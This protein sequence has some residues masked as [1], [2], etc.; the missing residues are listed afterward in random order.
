M[1][2]SSQSSSHRQNS[3]SES[4]Q[5]LQPAQITI[6]DRALEQVGDFGEVRL[7]VEKGKLRY[8][9]VTHSLDVLKIQSSL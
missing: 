9:E 6:I 5:F 2:N 1:D 3:T 7:V 8:I 4:L